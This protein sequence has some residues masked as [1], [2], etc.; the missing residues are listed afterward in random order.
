VLSLL[1][2]SRARELFPYVAG[3][4]IYLNHASTGPLSRLVVDAVR[5]HLFERS[6]GSLECYPSDLTMVRELRTGVQR[7]INAESPDRIAFQANTSDGLN[8]VAAGF[9]WRPGDRILLNTA[10]FPA[11]IYPF[12]NLRRHGVVID[13][14]QAP[15]GRVTLDMIE[16]GMAPAT[17]M[18][19]ISAVQFLSG[20]RADLGA[21]G[22]LCRKRDIAFVVDGIQ[23]IGAI[24]VDV[25]AARIDALSAGAQKWQL[26]PH[27][28][29]FL[30]ITEDL[31]NRLDPSYLGWL[32]VKTPWDFFNYEQPL[33]SSARRFEGGSLNMPGLWGMSASISTFLDFGMEAIGDHIL[34]LARRLTDMLSG[35]EGAILVSPTDA[36]SQS[37]I[38]TIR[39]AADLNPEH[40]FEAVSRRDITISLRQ[41]HLRFSPHF[42]NS[43]EDIATAVDVLRDAIAASRDQ[44]DSQHKVAHA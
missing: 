40:V 29:G 36:A 9:R 8:V 7:L 43:P 44:H 1:Q 4:K 33:A 37:G 34:E 31:Q 18:V 39:L 14:L 32:A 25:Q 20:Y 28:T 10:E 27:G 6:E 5:Q 19:A 24:P 12:L 3:G 2:L 21:I 41:G 30:Y 15:E 26:S 11:N 13:M 38:V 35:V 17:R 42:Y 23:A 16:S 22:A